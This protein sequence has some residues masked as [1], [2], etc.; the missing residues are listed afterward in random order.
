ME[1]ALTCIAAAHELSGSLQYVHMPF[2]TLQHGVD[3]QAANEFLGLD[4]LHERCWPV[5]R[6]SKTTRRCGKCAPEALEQPT[7]FR[8]S[9][10]YII[11]DT[12]KQCD[13]AGAEKT[14]LAALQRNPQGTC[15]A[16][17][18]GSATLHVTYDCFAFF[19]CTLVR[20]RRA[21]AWFAVL[22]MLR[23]AFFMGHVDVLLPEVSSTRLLRTEAAPVVEVGIHHRSVKRRQLSN[24]IYM[25]IVSALRER[26]A[27]HL[28]EH[29]A[30]R[31]QLKFV[32]HS[33]TRLPASVR[34]STGAVGMLPT[35][36]RAPDVTLLTPDDVPNALYAMRQLALTHV[37]I[38]SESSF[39]MV[40]ALLGNM[41]E[42]LPACLSRTPL[43]HWLSIPCNGDEAAAAA[44]IATM[45]WPPPHPPSPRQPRSWFGTRAKHKPRRSA[46]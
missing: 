4:L 39:S 24:V 22:P 19:W 14:W 33:D 31:L 28:R 12:S 38:P 25:R 7:R 40:P 1:A 2:H 42:L 46:R 35:L 5:V 26:H 23:A 21:R 45:P 44:V 13:S 27:A 17:I 41:T 10:K 30:S 34:N 9:P 32:I 18:G 15:G 37:L 11:D 8:L 20:L 36:G 3:V 6:A 16:P 43:P 29:P